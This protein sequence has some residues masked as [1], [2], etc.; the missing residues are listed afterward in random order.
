MARQQEIVEKTF[1]EKRK[2]LFA[3]AKADAERAVVDARKEAEAIRAR[4]KT[5]AADAA[6]KKYNPSWK[7]RGRCRGASEGSRRARRGPGKGPG[8]G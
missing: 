4:M 6:H 3:Q 8:G 2:E 7:K 5:E 1:E